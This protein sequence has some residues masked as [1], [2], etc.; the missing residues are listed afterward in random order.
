MWN[1]YFLFRS[2]IEGAVKQENP[3]ECV[4]SLEEEE[5]DNVK[6]TFDLCPENEVIRHTIR[7]NF[8]CKRLQRLIR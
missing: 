4:F 1:Q 3:K 5:E 7:L 6:A 8:Y 2:I